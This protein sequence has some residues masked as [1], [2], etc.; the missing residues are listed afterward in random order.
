M[1]NI[2]VVSVSP[3]IIYSDLG[4]GQYLFKQLQS[5]E[6]LREVQRT[7]K[8]Q[9]T[10]PVCS[11]SGVSDQCQD[12]QADGVGGQGYIEGSASADS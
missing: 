4:N 11:E 12:H 7:G 2:K 8:V 10:G 1:P 6:E 9:R 5:E 3:P